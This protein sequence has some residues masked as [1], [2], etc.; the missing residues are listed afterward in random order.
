MSYE[1]PRIAYFC[2]EY[3]LDE[4][5]PIYAGGL[6]VLAG[7]F[8]RSAH[9]LKLPV[10]GVG[11]AWDQG[12]TVQRIG[13]SGQPEDHPAALD[14]SLLKRELPVV[15]VTILGREVKLAIWRC[16]RFANAPLYLL[17]PIEER[18][19]FITRRLYGGG[20]DERVAQEMVLG[21]GGVR[22]LAALGLPI[23]LYHFNE[24]HAVFAGLELIRQ[25]RAHGMTFEAAWADARRQ[26]VFTTHTPVDAGNEQHDF[27]RLRRIGAKAG[28]TAP[29]LERIGGRPFNMTVAGLR[30]SRRANA[31]AELHGQTARNMWSHVRDAAPIDA[32][33]NGVDHRVWQDQ[34]VAQAHAHKS[35]PEIDHAHRS[36]KRDLFDEIAR[37]TA[38]DLDPDCLTIGFARRKTAYKRATLLFH[39]RA[40]AE[41]LLDSGKVQLVFA[42]KA[43]PRDTGGLALV[44]EVV[45][46]ARR[47]PGRVV[48]LPDYD[49]KLGRLLTRGCDVWLN[50]PRRPL[51]ACGTSGMK[52]AMNGV[53]NVSILD[54]WWV[55]GC[56]HGENGWQIGDDK[57]HATEAAAD[58][59]DASSLHDLLERQVI[60][61]FYGDRAR[62][63]DMMGASIDMAMEKFTADRMLR[64]YCDVLYR[65]TIA[66]PVAY[67][68]GAPHA[69]TGLSSRRLA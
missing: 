6:G 40:R 42:G 66:P 22:A 26:I 16:D 24:G 13:A 34:R 55:E 21:V 5:L 18:D 56:V 46:L 1:I 47:H 36:A 20:E 29:E 33:T 60:P 11:I 8:L 44:A 51:E 30:L 38:T 32:I 35:A 25:N 10:V 23:D 4:S 67:H 59:A 15:S 63:L 45:Q 61:T 39:Q 28:F 3:A 19:R 54:G 68:V 12:Y 49:L 2:M 64:D 52:A 65:P 31:V 57:E 43:H 37:L 27:E 48:F 69:E 50:T 41:A 58:L 53:L 9:A 17:D 62:W 14:R 7:D